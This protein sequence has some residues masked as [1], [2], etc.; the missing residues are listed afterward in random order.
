[1]V[2]AVSQIDTWLKYGA[3]ALEVD[4]QF[5]EDGTPKKFYHGW[6]CDF[7]RLCSRSSLV[8]NYIDALRERTIPSSG[9]FN[10]NLVLVM[11]DVKLK[12]LKPNVFKSAGEKFASTILMPLYK[13]NT[14]NMKVVVSFP[15][16]D[17]KD[18]VKGVL[19]KLWLNDVGTIKSVGFDVS[20]DDRSSAEKEKIF[21][22][23]GVPSGHAWLSIGATNWFFT[24]LHL[25][26][27]KEQVKYREEKGYFSKVYTWS[28]NRVSTAEKYLEIDLDGMITNDPENINEAMNRFNKHS[29]KVRLATLSDDPFKKY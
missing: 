23:V 11:F 3:N 17:Q 16:L 7:G 26:E 22:E 12:K 15:H 10:K 9:K 5:D 29:D 8:G 4:V 24:K 20:E 19:T 28:V 1:M 21:R 2:N 14:T 13:N 6:P 25:K 18:F 27:L